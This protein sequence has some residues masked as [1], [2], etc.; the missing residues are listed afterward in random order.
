MLFNENFYLI[1]SSITHINISPP[2]LY[3]Y[4]CAAQKKIKPAKVLWQQM[5]HRW[6]RLRL[7]IQPAKSLNYLLYCHHYVRLS[8][9]YNNY[10]CFQV[11]I[12]IT[13][14]CS[15]R[16]HS[17]LAFKLFYCRFRNFIFLS[18]GTVVWALVYLSFFCLPLSCQSKSPNGPFDP[19][20]SVL[21]WTF[22]V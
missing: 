17:M 13:K 1:F 6:P 7:Q 12:Y 2:S 18:N 4:R 20:L 14:N 16:S 19:Y 15:P 3:V 11:L 5:S 22:S 9:F 10:Q 8:T 21:R